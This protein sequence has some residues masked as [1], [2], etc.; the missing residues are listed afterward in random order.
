MD[1]CEQIHGYRPCSLFDLCHSVWPGR[2]LHFIEE[3]FIDPAEIVI[4]RQWLIRV[5]LD[6]HHL[7][8]DMDRPLY[9]TGLRCENLRE[10]IVKERTKD[11]EDQRSSSIFLL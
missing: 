11:E 4:E 5:H 1:I 8:P 6:H 2:T 9:S 10:W 7:F 3:V